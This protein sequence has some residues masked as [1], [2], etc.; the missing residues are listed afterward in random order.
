MYKA[1]FPSLISYKRLSLI[2][3]TIKS[4]KNVDALHYFM[5]YSRYAIEQIYDVFFLIF[6]FH[7]GL[8]E[9]SSPQTRTWFGERYLI[10]HGSLFS[11]KTDFHAFRRH[12][13]F[14][15]ENDIM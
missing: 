2:Q 6:I 15:N 4:L 12:M 5:G 11:L 9:R 14:L 8:W 1:I 3:V 13:L 10:S 7:C